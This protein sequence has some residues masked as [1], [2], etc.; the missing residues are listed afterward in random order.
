MTS[1]VTA[2]TLTVTITEL[3]TLNGAALGGTNTLD[4]GSINEVSKRIVTATTTE[5]E[6]LSFGAAFS[7]HGFVIGNVR[8]IR[9][10]NLDDTNSVT[11][12][13]KNQGNDECAMLL[14]KGQSFIFNGDLANGV[15]D[16][17]D[18]TE[19]AGVDPGLS[20]VGDLSNVTVWCDTASCDIEIFVA[21]I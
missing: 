4:I 8:Y 21:S 20:G 13:F 12:T 7:G 9:I 3:I 14:D 6:I 19:N 17:I 2:A 15:Q 10:T 11:L 16:V 18:C 5:T 1:T